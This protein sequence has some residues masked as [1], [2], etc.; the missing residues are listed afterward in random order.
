MFAPLPPPMMTAQTKR[1]YSSVTFQRIATWE[2]TVRNRLGRGDALSTENY[3]I[4]ADAS[5]DAVAAYYDS[6]FR[7]MGFAALNDA[8]LAGGGGRGWSS[9]NEVFMLLTVDVDDIDTQRP[10]Y[11][12]TTMALP[13]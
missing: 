12:L 1:G 11:V 8:V 2:K 6:A 9:E 13:D 4:A 5:F 3:Q 10:V 7:V